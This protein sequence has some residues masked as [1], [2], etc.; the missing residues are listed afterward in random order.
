M[1]KLGYMLV[2]LLV[3]L[4]VLLVFKDTVIKFS[5]ERAVQGVTG[6]RLNMKSLKLSLTKTKIDIKGLRLY[7]PRGFK[8]KVMLEMPEIYVD[9]DLPA[10]LKG[11][12]HIKDMRIDLKEF[13]VEKNKKGQLN[14]DSM[15]MVKQS[16]EQPQKAEKKPAEKKAAPPFQIDNLNLKVGTVYYKDYSQGGEPFV[17]EYDVGIDQNFQNITDLQSLVTLII[18]QSLARTSISQLANFGVKE[19]EKQI[20]GSLL[21][22]GGL[23][24]GEAGKVGQAIGGAVKKLFNE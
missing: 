6:L 12:V 9:I 19:L 11:A 7:N 18:V 13:T 1:K 3:I 24:S 15:K 14:L 8:D 4:M 5:I 22:A 21:P 23:L 20:T 16:K 10:L 2:G 17:K